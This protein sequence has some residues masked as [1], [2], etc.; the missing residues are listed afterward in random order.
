MKLLRALVAGENGGAL[1]P[2]WN[3]MM[4]H[5]HFIADYL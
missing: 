2:P 1:V 3:T 4:T 5:V